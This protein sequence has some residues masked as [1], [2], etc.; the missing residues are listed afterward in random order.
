MDSRIGTYRTH[1]QRRNQD[2]TPIYSPGR[3]TRVFTERT[4]NVSPSRSHR[5]YPRVGSTGGALMSIEL[6]DGLTAAIE[7]LPTTDGGV[8]L[9]LAT[10]G[11]PPA[12]CLLSSGDVVL[13]GDTLRIAVYS[14]SS[15][16]NRLGGSCTLLVPTGDDALRVLLD[17]AV[18][19]RAGPLSVIEGSIASLRPSS[20]PPWTLQLRF[21]ATAGEGIEDFVMFWARVRSWLRE[22]AHGDGPQPPGTRAAT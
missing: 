4:A 20:E 19:R 8:A 9:V 13:D 3:A 18:S 10:A 12:I 16:A 15:A 14:G 1:E 5:C 22:G 17:P 7:S 6:R 11:P 21:E 2:G